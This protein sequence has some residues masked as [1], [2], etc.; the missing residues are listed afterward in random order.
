M[1][2]RILGFVLFASKSGKEGGSAA[3]D[4]RVSAAVREVSDT[5]ENPA[6]SL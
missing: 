6:G 4:H 3:A 2:C 1:G 5:S